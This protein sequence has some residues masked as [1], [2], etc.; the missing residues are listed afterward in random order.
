M[1][2]IVFASR[3]SG[4]KPSAIREILKLSAD[5]SVIALSAGNP[6]A[7]SFPIEEV[8]RYTEEI[9]REEPNIALQYG[10]TEGYGPLRDLL[11]KVCKERYGAFSEGDDLIVTTGAQQAIDFTTKV[12]L[13]E[14]DTIIAEG[15]TF[16]GALTAF[17]SY[18][19][20][21]V[22]IPLTEGGLDPAEVENALKL[23][24]NA[25]FIYVIPNFQNPT[26]LTM[27]LKTRLELLKLAKQYGVF[28]LEDNPYHDLRFAGEE[29]P[30]IKSLDTDGIVIYVGSMSKILSPGLRV[31][32]VVA[33][34]EIIAKITVAKQCSDVH[35]PLLNQMICYKFLT[36]SDL[37]KHIKSIQGIYKLK[38]GL[39]IDALKKYG[40]GVIEFSEPEGGLFIWCTLPEGVD[41][42]D[43]C[44]RLIERKVA[45]VPGSAFYA[46]D[47]APRQTFRIN[48]SSPTDE[49][50]EKGVKA[51]CE[52][53]KEMLN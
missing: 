2:E 26:G 28:I 1:S 11:K 15:P 12:L 13:N 41:M 51:V 43:F 39:M 8:R 46:D 35:T 36:E 30:T 23:N 42:I 18:G 32:Y 27:P 44:K 6:S 47:A 24:P 48:F 52:L 5:P 50:I 7:A 34:K 25:R 40:E 29:L 16:V 37:P 9:L 17:R 3:V 45:V 33:K 49:N 19:A 20:N 38:S 22:Q 4:V 31:G 10:V 53:A 14:G 21:V